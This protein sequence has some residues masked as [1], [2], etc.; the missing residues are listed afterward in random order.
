V[1]PEDMPEGVEARQ[2]QGGRRAVIDAG[3]KDEARPSG[4]ALR[5]LRDG[6]RAI[7]DLIGAGAVLWYAYRFIGAD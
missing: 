1:K 6:S 4:C 2:N 3:K 7:G 5:L